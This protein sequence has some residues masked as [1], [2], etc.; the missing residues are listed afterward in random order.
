MGA[1][2]V[3]ALGGAGAFGVGAFVDDPDEVAVLA[4]GDRDPRRAV[5]PCASAELLLAKDKV[6]DRWNSL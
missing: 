1:L 4:V 6:L 5:A 2:G 3:G